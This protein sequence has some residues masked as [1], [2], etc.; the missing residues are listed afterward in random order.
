MG[1]SEVTKHEPDSQNQPVFFLLKRKTNQRKQLPRRGAMLQICLFTSS[2][3]P[4][5]VKDSAALG[6]PWEM[7]RPPQGSPACPRHTQPSHPRGHRPQLEEEGAPGVAELTPT[8]QTKHP[9]TRESKPLT[10]VSP[11]AKAQQAG[12]LYLPHLPGGRVSG[13]AEG[14]QVGVLLLGSSN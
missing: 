6:H 1:V 14:L 13:P 4:V 8:H 9:R 3:I 5:G 11:K 2:S 12:G 7:V 10:P